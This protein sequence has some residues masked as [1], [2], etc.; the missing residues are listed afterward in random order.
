MPEPL[1]LPVRKATPE[2]PEPQE[3]K[4]L[5]A[6]SVLPGRKV[7][8][9]LLGQLGQLVLMGQSGQLGLLEQLGQL[10]LL[11]QLVL[12]EQPVL[13]GQLALVRVWFQPT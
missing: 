9:V 10:G 4:A 7:I 8:L 1:V 13:P 6:Q 2:Q 11:E 12:L 5:L 3:R